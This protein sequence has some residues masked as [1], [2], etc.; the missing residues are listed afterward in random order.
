MSFDQRDR[1]RD[2]VFREM[3]FQIAQDVLCRQPV[4]ID[5]SAWLDR[6]QLFRATGIANSPRRSRGRPAEVG[7]DLEDIAIADRRE[8][9]NEEQDIVMQHGLPFPHFFEIA[10]EPQTPAL[11]ERFLEAKHLREMF[12]RIHYAA[13]AAPAP[14]RN[15]SNV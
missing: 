8:M 11:E 13:D 4:V 1:V 3:F 15:S 7:A 2:P 6:D 12:V 14:K 5:A 10:A 9:I